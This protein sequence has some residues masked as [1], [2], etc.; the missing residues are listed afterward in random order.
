MK[1]SLA[2]SFYFQRDDHTLT[3][4]SIAAFPFLLHFS[5]ERNLFDYLNE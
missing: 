4:K 3:D 1:L 5:S 2:P